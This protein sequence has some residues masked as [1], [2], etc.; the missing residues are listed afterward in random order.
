MDMDLLFS[1]AKEA[2]NIKKKLIPLLLMDLFIYNSNLEEQFSK[3]SH[4]LFC[5]LIYS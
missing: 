3:A 2:I 1:H 4:H 5:K